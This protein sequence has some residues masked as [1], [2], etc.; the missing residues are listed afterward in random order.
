MP[1]EVYIGKNFHTSHERDTFGRF[2]QEMVDC[3]HESGPLYIVAVEPE[4]NTS[5]LDLFVITERALI[6]VELKRL[7][8]AADKLEISLH[9]PESAPWK[10]STSGGI[11]TVGGSHNTGNP[12]RQV[13]SKRHRISDWLR[14]HSEGLP[15][16]PWPAKEAGRRCHSWVVIDPGFNPD[17]ST[18]DLPFDRSQWFKLL[19][20]GELRYQI[21]IA[22]IDDLLLEPEQMRALAELLGAREPNL[23]QFL[24]DY[25]PPAPQISFFSRPH[26]PAKLIGRQ[27]VCSQ[28][29]RCFEDADTKVIVLKGL[30][31]SGKTELAGW[32]GKQAA[33]SGQRVLW[34]DC[35]EREVTDEIFL[36][37]VAAEVRDEKHSGFIIDKERRSLADRM[38]AALTFLE[39]QPTLIVLDDF[40]KIKPHCGLDR[41][42]DHIVRRSQGIN[43]LITSRDHPPCLDN[44]AWAPGV[45]HEITV[46][47]LEKRLVPEFFA[48]SN[49]QPLTSEQTDMI[50]ERTSGNP[51]AMNIFRILM[52][53]RS[54]TGAGHA[55]PLY[56]AIESEKAWFAS[57]METVGAE[58]SELAG[59]LSVVR[60]PL[61]QRLVTFMGH[62]GAQKADE[63][64][65]ELFEK[66]ILHPLNDERFALYEFVREYLYDQ[67]PEKKKSKAHRDAG[68]HYAALASEQPG[69]ERASLLYEAVYHL[70]QARVWDELHVVGTEA[71]ERL[72][73]AGDW[74]RAQT[75]ASAALEAA[76]NLNDRTGQCAWLVRIADRELDQDRVKEAGR[77]LQEALN[78]LPKPGPKTAPDQKRR[79]QLIEAQIQLQ[80]GR[81]SY[82]IS[83]LAT[84]NRYFDRTL[85][86]ARRLQDG[87]LEADCLVRIG[88]I[89][90]HQGQSERAEDHFQCARRIAEEIPDGRLLIEAI[91]H[92]GLIARK[93]GR[94]QEAQD[95][96]EQAYQKALDA[97]DQEAVEINRSLLGDLARRANDHARAAPIFRECLE[98]S[99]QLGNPRGIRV[100]L[101]QL[102][103]S[104]TF[105]GA[106][107]EAKKLLDEAWQR[108]EQAG[109]DIGMAWTLKRQGQLLKVQSRIEEGNRLIERGIAVLDG[110]G[111]TVYQDDFKAALG[112]VQGSLF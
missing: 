19:S 47:G 39:E 78:L 68:K 6:T 87:H 97:G 14:D 109:D 61:N 18:L 77:H 34:V 23:K 25:S 31:G 105:L 72:V 3:F 11:Y 74:D 22:A 108:C 81:L 95:L 20:I 13:S 60:G 5:S 58:A 21:G 100:N 7:A 32:L 16:G 89:E 50:Y 45:T 104:L 85:E 102:A 51:R 29:L 15:G 67:L 91:S 10:Y 2:L 38:D 52:K 36:A 75:V 70:Q 65:G 35:P 30:G 55:L 110:I 17:T 80:K 82:A 93:R 63:L 101:G 4:I 66:Y 99:R 62:Q 73:Q 8:M 90:R 27:E 41:L 28:L 49:P 42:L 48:L 84:A 106:Y 86:I 56:T 24:P 44:P 98:L 57:L 107:D 76:A 33:G 92:L 1:V 37:A 40:H 96:F 71:F 111:N 64:V 83:D 12:Y 112:P 9:A 53:R 94:R 46:G 59:Q 79:L 88:R 103:E 54:G 69:E 43:V 26:L